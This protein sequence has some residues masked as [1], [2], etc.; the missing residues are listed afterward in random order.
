[1]SFFYK[2]K[3][4]CYF[5]SRNIEEIDYKDIDLI[6][7]YVTEC[8]KIIPSRITGVSSKHQRKLSLAIKRARYLA[9]IPYTDLH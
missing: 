8:N 5:S 7:N 2:K 1:M 3:K 9:L 4:N 6:K